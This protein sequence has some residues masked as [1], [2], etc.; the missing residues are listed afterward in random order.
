MLF[1]PVNLLMVI[2]IPYL[3]AGFNIVVLDHFKMRQQVVPQ[4]TLES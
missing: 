1:K 4:N 2:N 3:N